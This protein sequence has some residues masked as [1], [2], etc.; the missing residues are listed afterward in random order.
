MR[1]WYRASRYRIEHIEFAD[2]S[3]LVADDVERLVQ[4]L[5]TFRPP[6]GGAWAGPAYT[7]AHAGPLAAA[8][9]AA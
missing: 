6:Q 1:D 9:D 8:L 3:T 2:G 4:A 5:A 7:V